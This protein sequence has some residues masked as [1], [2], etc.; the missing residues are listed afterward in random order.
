MFYIDSFNK[1]YPVNHTV[2]T[3]SHIMF[4][5]SRMCG[6]SLLQEVLLGRI[7]KDSLS[8]GVREITGSW[9]EVAGV[10]QS[11][12]IAN[13]TGSPAVRMAPL[14]SFQVST[15]WLGLYSPK[16]TGHWMW[17]VSVEKMA[18]AQPLLNDYP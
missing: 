6:R 18:E 11:Y 7:F 2:G 8:K 10:I 16:H 13:S 12:H 1:Y 15:K 4:S 5:G 3:L 9:A 14:T 17:T